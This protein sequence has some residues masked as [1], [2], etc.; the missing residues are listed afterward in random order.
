M[1]PSQT[2]TTAQDVRMVTPDDLR[3]QVRL[4][5]Q[6]ARESLSH[7]RHLENIRLFVQEVLED[8]PDD[9][10]MLLAVSQQVAY[11]YLHHHRGTHGP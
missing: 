8:F 7:R 3:A 10:E 2:R 11:L 1:T 9:Q 6:K 5:E 4:W